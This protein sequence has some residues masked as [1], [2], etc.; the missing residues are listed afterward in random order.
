MGVTLVESKFVSLG[1]PAYDFSL[2][3]ADGKTYEL[4][5]FSDANVLVIVFMCNHCP[6]VQAVLDK[7]VMLQDKYQDQGVQFVGI[8]PNSAHPDYRR[9]ENLDRMAEFTEEYDMNFPYLSDI[10]QEVARE[11]D[12]QCTPDIFVYNDRRKLAYHGRVDDARGGDREASQYDLDDTL[13]ALVRGKPSRVKQ[14]PA[15]G[16]SIKWAD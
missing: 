1:L 10:D 13:D 9:E 15:M 3:G 7:L 14:F 11:Y 5:D 6:Y 8:N 4:D 16:C 2:E 12:A